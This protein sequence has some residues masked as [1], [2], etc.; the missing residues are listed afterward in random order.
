M[1]KFPD[2]GKLVQKQCWV[3]RC[4]PVK[5]LYL[6]LGAYMVR[7]GVHVRFMWLLLGRVE[8]A[9]ATL[10]QFPV[11][12]HRQFLHLLLRAVW[13]QGEAQ[14]LLKSLK[15]QHAVHGRK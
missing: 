4:L 1:L 11:H 9:V 14:Q 15:Y 12:V 3:H 2:M 10:T 8:V 7:G 6:P 13:L 5:D